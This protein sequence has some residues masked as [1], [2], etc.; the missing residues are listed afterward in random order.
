MAIISVLC[1]KVVGIQHLM[2][3]SPPTAQLIIKDEILGMKHPNPTHPFAK[4]PKKSFSSEKD[5]FGR[6]NTNLSLFKNVHLLIQ[7]IEGLF[8]FD[9]LLRRTEDQRMDGLIEES[10]NKEYQE[11]ILEAC[12]SHQCLIR[13]S[14]VS[15]KNLGPGEM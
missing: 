4:Q 10:R 15:K 2:H 9:V 6:Q 3:F 11:G 14:S 12:Q 1:F 8:D 7:Q 13:S 5:M